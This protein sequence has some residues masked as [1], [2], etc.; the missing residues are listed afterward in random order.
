MNELTVVHCSFPGLNMCFLQSDEVQIQE[1][2]D[3]KTICG[4][5]LSWLMVKIFVKYTLNEI[6]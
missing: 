6:D 3:F 1:S 4:R 5:T 2:W